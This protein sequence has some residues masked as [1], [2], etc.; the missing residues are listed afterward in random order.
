MVLVVPTEDVDPFKLIFAYGG[1][2]PTA[3]ELRSW[4]SKI[5]YALM[6]LWKFSAVRALVGETLVR[7]GLG[8][9][10]KDEGLVEESEEVP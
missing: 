1:I 10:K 7:S 5:V 8:F 3:M 2:L 9:L 4:Q 6:I